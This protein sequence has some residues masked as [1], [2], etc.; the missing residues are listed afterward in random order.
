MMAT[1]LGKLQKLYADPKAMQRIT[2]NGNLDWV[3]NSTTFLILQ[4]ALETIMVSYIELS[5]Y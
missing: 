5:M 2:F 1:D 3:G 4:E